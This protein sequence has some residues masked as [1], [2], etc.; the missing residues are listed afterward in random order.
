[1]AKPEAFPMDTVIFTGMVSLEEYKKT[2][3][4]EY[5]E[6]K[7]SGQLRKRLVKYEPDP[8]WELGVKIFGSI[9]LITGILLIILIIYSVLF[10][11]Q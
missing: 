3:P 6:L 10:G 7:N 4:R 11:Y 8:K 9:W 2:R 1:M 5:E